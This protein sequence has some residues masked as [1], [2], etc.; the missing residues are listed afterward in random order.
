V[1]AFSAAKGPMAN[2][3]EEEKSPNIA[4]NSGMDLFE[5]ARR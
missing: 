3:H 2:L 4:A 5:S 1:H